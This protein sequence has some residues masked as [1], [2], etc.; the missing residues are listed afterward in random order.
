MFRPPE[1][2]S[3][4]RF[5][6]DTNI[7]SELALM[8]PNERVIDWLR[9]DLP[10]MAL[11]Y[12][13]VAETARGIELL[14]G[15]QPVRAQRYEIWFEEVLRTDVQ[16]LPLTVE[17]A[18]LHG[19]MLGTRTLNNLWTSPPTKREPKVKL[20]LLVAA[21]AIVAGIPVATFNAKDFELI[22]KHF[23]LPGIFDPRKDSF[24][25]TFEPFVTLTA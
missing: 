23:P 16:W 9:R 17:V 18:R 21:Q 2:A 5:L 19:K 15:E 11:S 22:D 20:D 8:E 4:L 24:I 1:G 25:S 12:A 10:D 7:I 3:P 14:R 13:A 6:L